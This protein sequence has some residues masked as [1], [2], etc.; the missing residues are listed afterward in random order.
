[1]ITRCRWLPTWN[2]GIT[3]RL[4]IFKTDFTFLFFIDEKQ[5]GGRKRC[6][7]HKVY[8]FSLLPFLR[9]ADSFS[10]HSSIQSL[11]AKPKKKRKKN[12]ALIKEDEITF[13][14]VSEASF[15]PIHSKRRFWE[16]RMAI[17]SAKQGSHHL[18]LCR[19]HRRTASVLLTQIFSNDNFRFANSLVAS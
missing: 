1:M 8:V 5:T 16:E 12:A 18:C 3:E 13:I 6:C 10:A 7:S 4:Q 17:F 2:S 11:I 9:F 19:V 15:N 14:L